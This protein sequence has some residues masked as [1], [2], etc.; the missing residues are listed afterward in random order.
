MTGSL[1]GI[2]I[3]ASIV[4][5]YFHRVGMSVTNKSRS[6]LTSVIHNQEGFNPDL[7]YQT[8][9]ADAA[10]AIDQAAGKIC[11]AYGTDTPIKAENQI[12]IKIID[13]K[14]ILEVQIFENYS[15]VEYTSRQS[16]IGQDLLNNL[17]EREPSLALGRDAPKDIAKSIPK[18][19][20]IFICILVNNPNATFYVFEF[21]MLKFACE[22][23]DPKYIEGMRTARH[24]YD[25]I[26]EL[27]NRADKEDKQ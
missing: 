19:N 17:A 12:K 2:I 9:K 4:Y 3:I 15:I 7:E 22:K 20:T 23:D 21:M 6:L 5:Y 18:V 11:L 8:F 16:K 25:M 26:R 10:I 14:E 1:L 27:M 13:Y 24:W